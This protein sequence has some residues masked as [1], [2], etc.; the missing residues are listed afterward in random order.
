MKVFFDNK[1][2]PNYS[3]EKYVEFAW[4]PVYT[5]LAVSS[6]SQSGG[7]IVAI[8]QEEVNFKL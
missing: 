6:Y 7:Q 5:L 3:N 4:H 2:Q 1:I 8:Y